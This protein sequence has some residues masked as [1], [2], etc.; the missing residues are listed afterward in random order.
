M[1]LLM[2]ASTSPRR[3]ALLQPFFPNMDVVNPGINEGTAPFFQTLEEARIWVE[4]AA[5]AKAGSIAASDIVLSADT[6]VLLEGRVLGKPRDR[7]DAQNM[8]S[9]LAGKEHHVITGVAVSGQNATFSCSAV[10]VVEFKP[11]TSQDIEAYLDTGEYADK[12]GAYGIQGMGADLVSRLEGSW[13]NVVGLP[14]GAVSGLLSRFGLKMDVRSGLVIVVAGM[15]GAGKEEFVKTARSR[16]YAVVRMGDIVRETA[17]RTGVDMGDRGIGGFASSQRREHGEDV[18]AGRTLERL[19]ELDAYNVVVDGTRS[20]HE[21]ETFRRS[22][23][24]RMRLVA[25]EAS[26]ETRYKR[27]VARGR[28]DAPESFDDFKE[29]E[30]RESGWGI[31]KA[32]KMADVVISNDGSLE[33]FKQDVLKLLEE[34]EKQY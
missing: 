25:V 33:T 31:G 8:L 26:Q 1:L 19:K 21:V 14:L 30:T 5:V 4:A 9:S 13:S 23:G 17:L 28:S 24:S 3:R 7:E 27:L 16:L 12:A 6:I 18:W 2:L 29:R 34:L 15:P 11:L 20:H 10:S 22:L 32:I